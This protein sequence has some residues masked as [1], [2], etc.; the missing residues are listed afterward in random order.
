VDAVVFL[1]RT[2]NA[3]DVALLKQIGQL[4]GG[5]AGA[6]GIV[7]VASRADEIGAG[8]IDAMLSAADVAQRFTKEMNQTGIC[9]AVVPVSGLL[10]LTARTLRQSEFVGL[11]KLAGADKA[12]LSKAMLSVDRFVR[13]DS[14]LP[15]DAA[16]RA[17]L[18]ERFGMFGLRISIAV[19]AAGVS[20]AAGLADE[21]LERSGLVA[22]RAVIDQQF[23]QRSDMLKA[24]TALVSLRRFVEAFPTVATPYVIADIDPLLGD[25]HAFEELRL[26][27]QLHSRPTTL[28]EEEIV[29]LRRIIGGSGTQPASRLGLNPEDPHA[30]PRE[31]PRAAFAAAQR[32]RRRA[33]HPLND[34]FTTKACRAAVRSAEAMVA[35]FAAHGYDIQPQ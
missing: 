10:A 1:L 9:Q 32:W 26:I 22:L 29:S 2:L 27:S 23:A 35:D 15:V 34:P 17:Q 28:N 5:S 18:L 7:G 21:L 8:R 33:E 20:D 24:H 4:V 12:E 19:L 13:A 3:A 31:G 6:L 16:T 30:V 14:P 11:Q 25:T